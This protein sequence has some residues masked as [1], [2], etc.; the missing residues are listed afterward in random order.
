MNMLW[1]EPVH[2]IVFSPCKS[3]DTLPL[4]PYLAFSAIYFILTFMEYEEAMFIHKIMNFVIPA[5]NKTLK[6]QPT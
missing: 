6:I 3:P 1:G 4:H 5:G 2:W